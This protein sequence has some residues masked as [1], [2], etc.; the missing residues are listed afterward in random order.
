[1]GRRPVEV[2]IIKKYVGNFF[3]SVHLAQPVVQRWYSER[4]VVNTRQLQAAKCAL[5]NQLFGHI[6]T[7]L[8]NLRF[9]YCCTQC[10]QTFVRLV[11]CS[12]LG[13][14]IKNLLISV[15]DP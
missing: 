13:P 6:F 2:D 7:L 9:P 14:C 12:S 4:F 1:V 8:E 15:G 10:Q 11:V 5:S 3:K